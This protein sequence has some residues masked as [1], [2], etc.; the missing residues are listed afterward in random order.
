MEIVSISTGRF[1]ELTARNSLSGSFR[2]HE[3]YL[4]HTSNTLYG[5]FIPVR[6]TDGKYFFRRKS[7]RPVRF[8]L[9]GSHNNIEDY[10]NRSGS[11]CRKKIIRIFKTA[12][13]PGQTIFLTI[14]NDGKCINI[15]LAPAQ[16]RELIA[17]QI[18]NIEPEFISSVNSACK[19]INSRIP[20][21]SE[22]LHSSCS[23]IFNYL[24]KN[25]PEITALKPEIIYRSGLELPVDYCYLAY[26]KQFLGH[27]A[28]I[29][30]HHG[31]FRFYTRVKKKSIAVF[32]SQE[33][34]DNDMQHESAAVERIA[35]SNRDYS[36]SI[37]K[38]MTVRND[39]Y[40]LL[41]CGIFHFIGHG[42][43]GEKPGLLA[44]KNFLFN[45]TEL[46]LVP[47]VPEILI[48]SSCCGIDTDFIHEFLRRGGQ[49]VLYCCGKLPS[50]RLDIF[51]NSF[52]WNFL[53]RRASLSESVRIAK[54]NFSRFNSAWGLFTLA[55]NGNIKSGR[56]S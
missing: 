56:L 34:Q 52:Y 15:K 36:F 28:K 5:L 46:A 14:D 44:G 19:I 43:N 23:Y 49:A 38:G 32:I 26:Q 18:I 31:F 9:P 2:L 30:E 4:F 50:L 54:K 29:T 37:K 12:Q 39:F 53:Y 33:K 22:I 3:K 11:R 51:F 55:G 40:S 8:F 6:E 35:G 45:N 27:T 13:K 41:N 47:A 21:C 24:F 16:N 1:Q 17:S 25:F 7:Y 10:I 20:D 42:E 48:A